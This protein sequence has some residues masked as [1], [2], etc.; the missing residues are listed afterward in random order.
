MIS[1][2]SFYLKMRK[3]IRYL[4]AFVLLNFVL[5]VGCQS[6]STKTEQ[7]QAN[8]PNVVIICLDD[9]GYYPTKRIFLCSIV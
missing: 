2:H 6:K 1:S 7:T 8:K 4:G 5:M 3:G 9:L